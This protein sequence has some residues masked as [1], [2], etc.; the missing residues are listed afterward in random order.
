M[1]AANV[2]ETWKKTT[3]MGEK[4]RTIREEKYPNQQNP[5]PEKNK[6]SKRGK[7]GG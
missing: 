4:P 5:I 1:K 6:L 7:K 3:Y 2:L